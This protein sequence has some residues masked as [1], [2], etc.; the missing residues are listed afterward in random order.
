MNAHQAHALY[1]FYADDG[2]LL[3]VGITN[4]PGNRFNQ[5]GADKPWWHEV[6]GITME[7]YPDRASV[8]AAEARAIAVENPR[9]NRSRPT[10][11]KTKATPQIRTTRDLAW[12]CEACQQPIAD[13]AGYI[14]IRHID[15]QATRAAERAWKTENEH[16]RATTGLVIIPASVYQDYPPPAHWQTHHAKCDPDPDSADYHFDVARAR[17]HARLL[18]WTAHL[19]EK[20]WLSSTD[21]LELIDRMAGVDA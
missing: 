17:T 20:T 15:V 3:Y 4:N 14:H 16:P 21:W 6:R 1:R 12:I 13:G 2:T 8:L 10:L 7:P 18:H 5:H 9:Y 11:P 19:M